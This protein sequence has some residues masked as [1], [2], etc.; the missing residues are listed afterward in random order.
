MILEEIS[1]KSNTCHKIKK[2]NC[3]KNLFVNL[4]S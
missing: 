4:L 2:N 1:G 3:I